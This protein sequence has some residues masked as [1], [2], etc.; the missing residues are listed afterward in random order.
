MTCFAIEACS[1]LANGMRTDLFFEIYALLFKGLGR[2][3]TFCANQRGCGTSLSMRSRSSPGRVCPCAHF[4]FTFTI[5]PV[6]ARRAK[7]CPCARVPYDRPLWPSA[8]PGPAMPFFNPSS[9]IGKHPKPQPVP[10]PP[11]SIFHL[12]PFAL[13]RHYY[14]QIISSG[15]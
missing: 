10:F 5:S 7:V 6:R 11:S 1:G 8:L 4:S 9:S 14:H 3:L 15:Q 13:H 12:P 2:N